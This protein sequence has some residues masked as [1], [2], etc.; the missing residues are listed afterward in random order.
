M[1]ATDR[2]RQGKSP[3]GKLYFEFSFPLDV[4][5][6]LYIVDNIKKHI[7]FRKV[8]GESEHLTQINYS[9]CWNF[10]KKLIII[11]EVKGDKHVDFYDKGKLSDM[12]KKPLMLKH[13]MSACTF[14][15]GE[16]QNF[17]NEQGVI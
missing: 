14:F 7:S 4:Q 8:E 16:I 12:D 5:E 17:M 15:I 9:E 10:I 2:K 13:T 11:K 6:Q 1:S 3:D